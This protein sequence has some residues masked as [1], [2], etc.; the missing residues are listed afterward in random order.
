MMKHT[1][2]S[3]KSN[4]D[5]SNLQNNTNDAS[6]LDLPIDV[7]QQIAAYL[8][9]PDTF[10]LNRAFPEDFASQPTYLPTR[11]DEVHDPS[12]VP[13]TSLAE[14]LLFRSQFEGLIDVLHNGVASLSYKDIRDIIILQ[15]NLQATGRS[16]LLLSGS[17][18]VQVMT[19]LRFKNSDLDFYVD[20]FGLRALRRLLRRLGFVC[21]GV[22]SEYQSPAFHD[23]H[24]GIHH[25]ETYVLPSKGTGIKTTTALKIKRRWYNS[26]TVPPTAHGNPL[27][28]LGNRRRGNNVDQLRGRYSFR[29]DDPFTNNADVNATKV[30]DVVVTRRGT[31]PQDTIDLFDLEICKST[32]NGTTFHNPNGNKT[33]MNTTAWQEEW[34]TLINSYM[35]SFLLH[36]QRAPQVSTMALFD[37]LNLHKHQKLLFIMQSLSTAYVTEHARVPC[38]LH[39]F[40]C[41]CLDHEFDNEYFQFL[42]WAIVVRFKRMMKYTERGISMPLHP[43]IME[44]IERTTQLKSPSP[45]IARAKRSKGPFS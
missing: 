15:K 8:P 33:F 13:T 2:M 23:N 37:N 22:T 42:H 19:G 20:G 18:M 7:L 35:Q 45:P 41:N 26:L 44:A 43:A 16:S 6:I 24:E 32:W 10:S 40:N 14:A 39:G 29:W 9:P 11:L 36:E 3:T 4:T 25:V 21:H 17:S 34:G 27:H 12:S 30:C 5:A 1:N 38:V 28:S 31:T